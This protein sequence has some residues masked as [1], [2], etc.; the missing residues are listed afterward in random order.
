MISG[1]QPKMRPEIDSDDIGTGPQGSSALGEIESG[2]SGATPDSSMNT[3]STQMSCAHREGQ[4]AGAE[5]QRPGGVGREVLHRP[6]AQV[7]VAAPT[8]DAEAGDGI[9][10]HDPAFGSVGIGD[11]PFDPV[12]VRAL[13]A[14]PVGR[15][16]GGG[17]EGREDQGGEGCGDLV[18]GGAELGF[19][20]G[21]RGAVGRAAGQTDQEKVA[22]RRNGGRQGEGIGRGFRP[23]REDAAGHVSR[24]RAGRFPQGRV[25]RRS[26]CG[27]QGWSP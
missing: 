2:V 8:G 25:S 6:A 19:R 3:P 16:A 17:C 10:R 22:V 9:F 20:V 12:V 5:A 4:C 1:R 27:R 7:G 21:G 11:I 13:P 15:G 14:E 26:G 24:S 23:R 18:E